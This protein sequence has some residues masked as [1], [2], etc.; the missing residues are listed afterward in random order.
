MFIILIIAASAIYTLII[1]QGYGDRLFQEEILDGSAMARVDVFDTFSLVDGADFWLGN[2]RSYLTVM[3]QLGAGGVENSYI[4]L[5]LNHGIVIAMILIFAYALWL[6]TVVASF[7]VSEKLIFFTS[8]ILVGSF[9]NSLTDASSWIVF[10]I[11]AN[12]VPFF[13]HQLIEDNYNN[14]RYEY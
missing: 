8:F 12:S 13:G 6:R 9:N 3:E 1:D 2:S 14:M 4:V 5:I 7:K 11:C 10:V